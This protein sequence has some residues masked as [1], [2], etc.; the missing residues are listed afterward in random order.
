EVMGNA[1]ANI[2]PVTLELGGKSPNLVLADAD[3]AEA[4]P[5]ILRAIIQNAGQT[6]SAGTRVIVDRRIEADLVDALAERMASVRMGPGIEDPDMGPLI[7]EAQLTRV[8]GYVDRGRRDGARLLAGGGRPDDPALA[9][10][11]FFEPTLFTGVKP[12]AV[13]AQE[14]IFGPVLVSLPFADIDEAVRLANDTPYGLVCAIWTRDIDRAL[15]VAGR[16]DSGQVFINTYGAGG[17]V[18]LPFG[19][20]K[21]SGFG[22][23][24]GLEAVVAYTQTKTVAVRIRKPS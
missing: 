18:E 15:W 9:R 10:G 4:V 20:W 24:K 7:S 21:H 3:L 19:G 12:N 2:T 13:I 11:F 22:R 23:E 1:A 16:L 17:G 6:C 5:V 14:E 8:A